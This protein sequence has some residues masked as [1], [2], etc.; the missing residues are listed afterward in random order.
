M[1][2]AAASG[3]RVPGSAPGRG[4]KAEREEK[5]TALRGLLGNKGV[6]VVGKGNEAGDKRMTGK[7]KAKGKGGSEAAIVSSGANLKL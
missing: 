5:D 1:I 2:N 7:G 3:R 6:S 4:K